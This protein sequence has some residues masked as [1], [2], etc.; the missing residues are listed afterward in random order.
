[1]TEKAI[2]PSVMRIEDPDQS[3]TNILLNK[4]LRFWKVLIDTAQQ[5]SDADIKFMPLLTE[6]AV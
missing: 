5:Q 3:P 4:N 1:M 6:G 2:K